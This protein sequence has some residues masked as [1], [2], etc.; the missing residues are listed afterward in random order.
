[1]V[2]GWGRG[3]MLAD[4]KSLIIVGEFYSTDIL[5]HEHHVI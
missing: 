1:M 5:D 4:M 3:W 2:R